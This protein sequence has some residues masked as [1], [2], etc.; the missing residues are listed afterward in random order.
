MANIRG[1]KALGVAMSDE[2]L[3]NPTVYVFSHVA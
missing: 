3:D 2:L 1:G